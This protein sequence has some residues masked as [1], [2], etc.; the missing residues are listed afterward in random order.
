MT[1]D[2]QCPVCRIEFEAADTVALLPCRH[3]YHPECIR[4]WLQHN[5]ARARMSRRRGERAAARDASLGG[6]ATQ[7]WAG[8]HTHR[9]CATLQVCCICGHELTHAAVCASDAQ[10]S[11]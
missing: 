2:D 7:C 1:C 3:Y 10:R 9:A 6:T 11:S 8:T 5:K 4:G